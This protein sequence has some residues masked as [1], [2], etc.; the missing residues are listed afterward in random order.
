[1]G[2]QTQG[3][4]LS[5][6][7]RLAGIGCLVLATVLPAGA[8]VTPSLGLAPPVAAFA[9]G[10][11]MVGGPEVLVVAAALLLG[12]KGLI[13]YEK[14]IARTI[15]RPACPA[16]YYAGVALMLTNLTLLRWCLGVFVDSPADLKGRLMIVS[17][18][19]LSFVLGFVM[20]G[21]QFW[22]KAWGLL[23]YR[24]RTPEASEADPERNR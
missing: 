8:L 7:R 2:D 4:P 1:V 6:N 13:H 23:L 3:P 9:A 16:R 19:D 12:R 18:T 22:L 11:C 14:R 5:R 15:R 21:P 20:A 17:L 10:A 24:G